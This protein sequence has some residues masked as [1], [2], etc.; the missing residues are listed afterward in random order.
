MGAGGS[1]LKLVHATSRVDKLLLTGV[2][3]MGE[4]ADTHEVKRI[5]GPVFPFRAEI[6]VRAGPGEELLSGRGIP[7]NH[8]PVV[9]R[10]AVG[11]HKFRAVNLIGYLARHKS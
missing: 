3:W 2:K 7:E 4:C 10:M 11:L 5:L 1:L 8:V 9:L 6:G